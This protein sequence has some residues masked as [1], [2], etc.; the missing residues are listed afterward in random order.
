VR[1]PPADRAEDR[2]TNGQI[3]GV[4][5]PLT[6]DSPSPSDWLTEPVTPS[7]A[8]VTPEA[9]DVPE[10]VEGAG[11][12]EVGVD[13]D[14]GVDPDPDEPEAVVGAAEV[15][16]EAVVGV[17]VPVGGPAEEPALEL[18]VVPDAGI[19][20]P[21]LPLTVLD[22]PLELPLSEPAGLPVPRVLAAKVSPVPRRIEGVATPGWSAIDGNDD[23][24]PPRGLSDPDA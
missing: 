22:V 9:D 7:T 15:G 10:P 21:V 2:M 17:E 16:D 1:R 6:S 13:V 19:G 23:E 18:T 24:T 20:L 12:P 8:S 14:V 3:A 11:G 4:A 5:I